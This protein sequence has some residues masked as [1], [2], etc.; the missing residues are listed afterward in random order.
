MGE[1]TLS[2]IINTIAAIN[3]GTQVARVSLILNLPC[4]PVSTSSNNR[5][6]VFIFEQWPTILKVVLSYAMDPCAVCEMIKC[7]NS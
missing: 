6:D 4:S 5:H 2:Y 3:P 7:V 1:D